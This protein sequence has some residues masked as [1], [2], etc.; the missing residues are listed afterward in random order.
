VASEIPNVRK[1]QNILEFAIKNNKHV[2]CEKPFTCSYKEAN[3][4]CNLIKR[5]KNIS[6]MVNYEFAEIDAFLFFKI[7]FLEEIVVGTA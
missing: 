6:H 7:Y 3:L 4:V 5:K 1:I 2:F